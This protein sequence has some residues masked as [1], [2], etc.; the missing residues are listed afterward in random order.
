M[1]EGATKEQRERLLPQPRHE[2][3][4][5]FSEACQLEL[6]LCSAQVDG[7]FLADPYLKISI[8]ACNQKLNLT[9]PVTAFES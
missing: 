3:G 9:P 5:N 8:D 7:E 2:P 6:D 1:G 4:R